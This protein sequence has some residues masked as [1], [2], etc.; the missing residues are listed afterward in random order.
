MSQE[1]P[2]S[3]FDACGHSVIKIELSNIV[4]TD[5]TV[6]QLANQLMDA[7]RS[8]GHGFTTTVWISIVSNQLPDYLVR[9][10]EY[11]AGFGIGLVITH[12]EK[13]SHAPGGQMPGAVIA[14]LKAVN[15]GGQVWH[16][17]ANV[18]V[19]AMP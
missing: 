19:D 2:F 15:R 8:A 9:S 12:G 3:R 5:A 14:G 10:I 18:L 6:K 11:F 13:C 16:P 17:L 1:F 4:V 7:A